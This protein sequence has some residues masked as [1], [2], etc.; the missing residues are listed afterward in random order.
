[1]IRGKGRA[2]AIALVLGFALLCGCGKPVLRIADAS[3]GDYYTDEEF[4]KLREEQRLEY[5]Q[6]LAEQDSMYREEIAD[7]RSAADRFASRASSAREAADS[8]ARLAIA[9]SEGGD[10]PRA[11]G[12]LRSESPEPRRAE[13]SPDQAAPS[14]QPAEARSRRG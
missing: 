1:V 13:A 11:G 7:A 3:L 4:K 8:L 12:R 9:G 2:A 6:E 14:R 10:G 5:C